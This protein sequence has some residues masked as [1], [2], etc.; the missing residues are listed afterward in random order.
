[1]LAEESGWVGGQIKRPE[2]RPVTMFEA[3]ALREGRTI[4]DLLYTK[5]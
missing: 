5:A 4:T 3:R 2:S 1:V